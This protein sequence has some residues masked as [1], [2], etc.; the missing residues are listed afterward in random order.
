MRT[1]DEWAGEHPDKKVFVQLGQTSFRP[2]HCEFS[3]FTDPAQWES[4]FQESELVVSHAGMGT[5]LKSLEYAKPLI[6]MPRLASLGEHRN[7]HQAA[8]AS[9][10][11]DF[12][13]IKIVHDGRELV[14]ALDS[15]VSINQPVAQANAGNLHMLLGEIQRFI[16]ANS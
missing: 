14:H 13:N 10:F 11:K 9:R 7:D 1:V 5:I 12:W 6:V 15:P 4:L 8:T 3:A 2:R 16:D